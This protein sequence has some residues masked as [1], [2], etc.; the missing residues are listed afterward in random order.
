M[1][2]VLT[3]DLIPGMVI[4]EDVY[5]YNNQL[6]LPEGMELNDKAITKLE[7]YSILSVRIK[8]ETAGIKASPETAPQASYSE[9]IKASAEFKQFKK[10]FESSV[11]NFQGSLNDIVSKRSNGHVDTKAML[12]EP[13]KLLGGNMSGL[14]LFDMLHNM[15][16]YDDP[17]Y[18]HCLNVALI[19]NVF[20]KWLGM[21][22]SDL[23]ILTLCG[24]L[25]DVG[26]LKI[27]G[28][29]IQKPARLTDEE[30]TVIKTHTIE[31]FNILKDLDISDH[32]KN[33]ALMHHERCDGTGYPLG[34]TTARIDR[35]ARI[36]SIADV[37]DAMTSAR[38]YRGPLCPFQVISIFETEGLQK[39][40]PQYILVFL[41]YIVNTYLNNRVRLSNGLEGEIVLINKLDLSKPMVHVGSHYI[42][43]S[44]EHGLYV[45]AIL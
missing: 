27:P 38:V 3:Q 32:I 14:H 34:L 18:A 16:M 35:F 2:R 13:E 4:A 36:V 25:H 39:Y 23:D 31:G 42:D 33:A 1:P 24:L 9:K 45:E 7:F 21:A 19:C 40:D 10:D 44:H 17:T 8:E 5:T 41:E 12:A 37:Y 43:L 29:I 26:K 11:E 22:Q 28:P 6:I 20:G 15:R 30:Y